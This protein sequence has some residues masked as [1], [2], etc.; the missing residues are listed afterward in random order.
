M[1]APQARIVF[2]ASQGIARKAQVLG[3]ENGF[4]LGGLIVLAAIPLCLLLKP[5]AHHLRAEEKAEESLDAEL[6]AE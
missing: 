4:V 5:S 6:L 3:F 2:A 1:A